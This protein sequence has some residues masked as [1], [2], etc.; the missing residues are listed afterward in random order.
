LYTSIC[1][2][3][4]LA[5]FV[6]STTVEPGCR[7]LLFLSSSFQFSF[8]FGSFVADL[9]GFTLVFFLACTISP[10]R[11]GYQLFLLV[12]YKALLSSHFVSSVSSCLL[13]SKTSR[14]SLIRSKPLMSSTFFFNR[15]SEKGTL[16]LFFIY[17]IS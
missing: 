4:L 16:P 6:K 17:S 14:T 15:R 7:W 11:F 13:L 10:G 3:L 5:K 8:S 1:P 12:F 2:I 9:L